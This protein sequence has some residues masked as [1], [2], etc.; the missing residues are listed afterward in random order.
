VTKDWP[1]EPVALHFPGVTHTVSTIDQDG[2]GMGCQ[3]Y[4]FLYKY[5]SCTKL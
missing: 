5:C 3:I 2:F 1:H 4:Y